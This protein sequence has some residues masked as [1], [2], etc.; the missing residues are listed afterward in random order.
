MSKHIRRECGGDVYLYK[1]IENADGYVESL[2]Y[3]KDE[4]ASGVI[5]KSDI[6]RWKSVLDEMWNTKRWKVKD[7]VPVEVRRELT[8][9]EREEQ[10]KECVRFKIRE[11]Y[12]IDDELQIHRE[13]AESESSTAEFQKYDSYVKG[14]V[15]SHKLFKL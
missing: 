14:I 10:R 3:T 2:V 4:S 9:E 11:N 6:D 1:F 8:A 13:N 7:G 15:Q 12:N 5:P